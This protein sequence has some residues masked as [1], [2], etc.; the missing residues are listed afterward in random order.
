MPY[1]ENSNF[2]LEIEEVFGNENSLDIESSV[3]VTRKFQI[4]QEERD[5]V[6]FEPIPF[7]LANL[8]F[9][10]YVMRF[11]YEYHDLPF[12]QIRFVEDKEKIGEIFD[13]D[14]VYSWDYQKELD[15][16]RQEI[17]LPTFS[18]IGGKKQQ[19]L[20]VITQVNGTAINEVK[21][22]TK[23]SSD[24]LIE[25]KML[26]WDGK[27]YN[28]V[29]LES[30]NLKFMVPAWYP[31]SCFQTTFMKRLMQFVGSVNLYLFYGLEPGECKY[32]GPEQSW[33]TRTVETGSPQNPTEMIR[34]VELQHQF[35]VQLTRENVKIG[36][37]TIPTIPG[38]DYVDVHY[39]EALVD[40]GD[41]NQT[42][43]AIAQQVDIVPVCKY[44]DLWILF[45]GRILEG[46]WDGPN[47]WNKY[48]GMSP[49]D[50]TKLVN[51]AFE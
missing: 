51:R 40:I 13:A 49:E 9:Y 26:G 2:R 47:F 41:G 39:E 45:D 6:D 31:A 37:I 28:G 1:W 50:V 30:P 10:D 23:S 35:Q 8:I 46:L 29:E 4:R 16:Q 12:R 32:L 34:C 19:L 27:K 22:Y 33:V 20:P 44:K 11:E 42:P 17:T 48:H 24:T 5:S 14:V 15:E 43:L 38:W 18:I 7:A 21:R 25:Y 3:A 36:D